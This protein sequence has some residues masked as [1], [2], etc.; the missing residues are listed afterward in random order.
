MNLLSRSTQG[1]WPVLLLIVVVLL[2]ASC[3]GTAEV[4]EASAAPTGATEE[5]YSGVLASAQDGQGPYEGIPAGL[6]E[7]GNPY[8]GDPDAPVTLEEYSDFLCPFCQRHFDQTVPSLIE[9]YVKTGQVRYVFHDMPLAGLHPT[10]PSG[11]A[12]ARC[13]AEQ[14]SARF[15]SMHDE[16]FV[17]QNEWSQLSD[18][19][20]FLA[21]VAETTGVDKATYEECLAEG[22]AASQVQASVAAGQAL[23]FNGTPSFQLVVNET[24]EAYTLVG[25]H[26]LAEFTTRLDALVAGEVPPQAE[27]A[28]APEPGELPFWANAEG[29]APDP[30]R[31]GFTVAGDPYKGDPEANLVVVEFAD[32]QCPACQVHALEVQPVL[33]Q[34]F[35]DSGEILWVFK[36]LPLKEHPH[37][38]AAATAA[39]CA[40]AQGMFWE[41][42]HLL[43]ERL[44]AWSGG[45]AEA[46][47]LALADEL[48]LES[49]TFLACFNGRQALERVLGDLYDA[50]GVVSTTPNFV[51]LYGGKGTLMESSLPAEQFVT[52]L[53]N[54]LESVEA[55]EAESSQP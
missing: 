33:D 40:G 37:A 54:R 47:L 20:A 3:G 11:H 48:G 26:P 50:Q 7:E 52:S 32:F 22:D 38:P 39:E 9:Q 18:P 53:Q 23:G 34:E 24:G 49:A 41:M 10:A 17:R 25:A 46:G 31:P 2:L 29:L 8:L 4:P 19:T 35:V 45:D 28:A 55:A 16:L 15:W 13:A 42:H 44:E 43:F 51:I 12:A 1:P 36:N 14:G 5:A 27:E 30:Q 6:T 21:G